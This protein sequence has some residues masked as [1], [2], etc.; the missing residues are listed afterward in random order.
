MWSSNRSDTNRSVP[1]QKQARSLKF[2]IWKVDEL[3]YPCSDNKGADQLRGYSAKL[4]CAFV[5]RLCRLLVFP[6]GGS[7]LLDS[8]ILT[9][10][11]I[12]FSCFCPT[13]VGTKIC[14]LPLV[15][16]WHNIIRLSYSFELDIMVELI[17]KSVFICVF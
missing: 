9:V 6:C 8:I 7:F 3:Y 4:I 11:I 16:S 13:R 1:S 15:G 17:S 12:F 5:F 10:E 2:W 14:H